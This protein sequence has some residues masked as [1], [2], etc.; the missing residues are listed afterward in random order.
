MGGV[1]EGQN[2]AYKNNYLAPTMTAHVMT[3]PGALAMAMRMADGKPPG[4]FPFQGGE[5]MIIGVLVIESH[6]LHWIDAVDVDA[7]SEEDVD[8]GGVA[9]ARAERDRIFAMSEQEFWDYEFLLHGSLVGHLR[10]FL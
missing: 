10:Q 9:H 2:W 8:P 7:E 6:R 3:T 4:G 5:G 1:G